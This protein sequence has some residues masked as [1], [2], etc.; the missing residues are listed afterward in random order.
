MLVEGTNEGGID[1]REREERRERERE[2]M[3]V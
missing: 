3:N 2:S 1:K